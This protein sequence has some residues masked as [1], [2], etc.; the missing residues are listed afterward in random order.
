MSLRSSILDKLF[1]GS[2][3]CCHFP[4]TA[5]P[6]LTLTALIFIIS[7]AC[8]P[9]IRTLINPQI[10]S[11]E[12]IFLPCPQRGRPRGCEGSVVRQILHDEWC[13]GFVFFFFFLTSSPFSGC[14]VGI[15]PVTVVRINWLGLKR[16]CLMM[17]TCGKSIKRLHAQWQE[18]RGSPSVAKIFS[19]LIEVFFSIYP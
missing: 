6:R 7:S 4:S 2:L 12:Y 10:H 3:L 18:C 19:L 14:S 15:Y 1:L 9:H 17:R 16:P 13:G 5:S 8:I 11:L